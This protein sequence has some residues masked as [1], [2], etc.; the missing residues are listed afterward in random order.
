MRMEFFFLKHFRYQ[1]SF[2]LYKCPFVKRFQYCF[3][4]D[5]H[6]SG[7]ATPFSL[8]NQGAEK[9]NWVRFGC[10]LYKCLLSPSGWAALYRASLSGVVDSPPSEKHKL[11]LQRQT[12][13]P[14][15]E[16]LKSLLFMRG[17]WPHVNLPN[18]KRTLIWC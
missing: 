18:E 7:G 13:N 16:I 17:L 2:V 5:F 9:R 14:R 10:A 8:F 3:R 12:S 15:M 11:A 4:D 6:E 1:S